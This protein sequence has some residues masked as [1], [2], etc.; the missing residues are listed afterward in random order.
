VLA[1]C[2]GAVVFLCIIL[3]YIF[4]KEIIKS[5][6]IPYIII[7]GFMIAASIT[8]GYMR[9]ILPHF[10]LLTLVNTVFGVVFLVLTNKIITKL[11]KELESLSVTDELTKIDNRRA[12]TNYFAMMWNQV[13]RLHLPINVLMIDIDYFK[14]YN[15]SLGHLAG[16]K[17]LIAVAK[18]LKK[19]IQR[20]TDFV[21]RFGGEEFVC[22]L[23]YINKVDA[24]KFAKELV[25]SIEDMKIPHPN[26]EHSQYLTISAG[27]AS[28][29]PQNNNTAK[30]L[31][32]EADKALYEA[33]QTG[34]NRVVVK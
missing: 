7:S 16:D 8:T 6:I 2:G 5:V 10:P 15:D 14:K 4:R 25:K 30:Q 22:I 23:S 12:F 34:R 32:D 9:S 19:E 3:G 33:K 21:A 27:L 29:V 1:Y 20:T 24:E 31:L 18:C 11:N 13:T 28:I 17:A 26:S